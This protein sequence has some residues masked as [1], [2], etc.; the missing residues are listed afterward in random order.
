[1][2]PQESLSEND[3]QRLFAMEAE[4]RLDTLVDELLE[5]EKGGA[6]PEVVASLFR[7]AH[8]IKG[9]AAVVGMPHVARV[10]HALE[11]LL[12]EVRRERR[13][14]DTALI[15]AVLAGVDAIRTLIPLAVAGQ[16]HEKVAFDAEQ[17]L[18]IAVGGPPVVDDKAAAG[19]APR[20][21]GA[22]GGRAHRVARG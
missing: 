8:T 11:D 9:G 7:E 19:A 2:S 1:M 21:V 17:R 4:G 12:E 18:R 6:T 14:V 5:L 22:R 16:E 3:F 20:P 15:D 10:A 13:G